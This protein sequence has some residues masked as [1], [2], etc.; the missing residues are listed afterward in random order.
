MKKIAVLFT[1]FFILTTGVLLPTI[2][3][4]SMLVQSEKYQSYNNYFTPI[5]A[6]SSD[7]IKG[8]YETIIYKMN[9][10]LDPTT[11]IKS[12]LTIK[13]IQTIFSL[14]DGNESIERIRM[15]YS[16]NPPI[17]KNLFLTR[18][19]LKDRTRESE[20]YG[21]I[22]DIFDNAISYE[23]K[24]I[25]DIYELEIVQ[26][27][28]LSKS[29][30]LQLYDHWH[31]FL[32]QNPSVAKLFDL[33]NPDLVI[34]IFVFLVCL[35]AYIFVVN[36]MI[37]TVFNTEFLLVLTLSIGVVEAAIFGVVMSGFLREMRF[38][39]LSNR[40]LIV[41]IAEEVIYRIFPSLI[42]WDEG[43]KEMI[44]SSFALLFLVLFLAT[45]MYVPAFTFF[46]AGLFSVG[47]NIIISVIVF[48]I[49]RIFI[50]K[51]L[52]INGLNGMIFFSI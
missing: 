32:L 22:K 35:I 27:L 30:L 31:N 7:E 19:L 29:Q 52:P 25:D 1:C 24:S 33:D 50:E 15:I 28:N 34:L 48:F 16:D 14:L 4:E 37:A 3:S 23:F 21:E 45:Y 10:G 43:I 51:I 40:S 13:E 38:G 18:E 36:G 2:T 11:E 41:W 39:I 49:I 46:C 17:V 26:T 8:F 6:N 47:F 5:A 9:A 12:L 20:R 42:A 44:S